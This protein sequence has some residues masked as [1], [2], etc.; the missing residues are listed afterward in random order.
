MKLAMLF[1]PEFPIVIKVGHAEAGYGMHLTS[2]PTFFIHYL[3][4]RFSVTFIASVFRAFLVHLAKLC[5]FLGKMRFKDP[6][7]FRDFR[8]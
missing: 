3:A 6:D 8:G 1:T 4:T 7:E 5:P 2:Y